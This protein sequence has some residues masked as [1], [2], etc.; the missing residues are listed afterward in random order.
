MGEPWCPETAF[1]ARG[2][3]TYAHRRTSAY[4]PTTILSC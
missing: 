1:V 4:F 2:R 3:L